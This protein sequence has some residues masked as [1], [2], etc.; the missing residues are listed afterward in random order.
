MRCRPLPIVALLCVRAWA[1][2][3]T[4]AGF[5]DE[6]AFILYVNEE[7]VGRL[8]F[9]WK[10]DG[11][12]ESKLTMSLAGQ[13]ADGIVVLTP[14]AE[15]RWIKAV[16]DDP[17][18]KIVWERKGKSYRYTSPDRSDDQQWPE[19]ALTF[20]P[21]TP[22]LITL[23]LHRFDRNGEARQ[24]L[25]GLVL[26]AKI[27]DAN[28]VVERQDTVERVVNGRR[29]KLTRWGYAPAGFAFHV[30]AGQG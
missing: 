29:V 18:H 8:T 30:L 14:D 20:E 11:T 12:F 10:A 22:P 13:S 28:L 9:E 5:S 21:W 23:A 6:G 24:T 17:S 19:D 26:Y 7:R 3:A 16:V 2:P 27:V 25:P 4:L 15:G 1:Q